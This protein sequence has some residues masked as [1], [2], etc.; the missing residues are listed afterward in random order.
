MN[1]GSKQ[2]LSD[3]PARK[4]IGTCLDDTLMVEAGAGTGKTWSLVERMVALISSGKCTAGSMAAVTFTRKA[5][6]ELENRFQIELEKA[7]PKAAEPEQ[8]E[9]IATALAE[10]DSAFIGTIHSFCSRILRERPVEAGISPEFSE[11]EGGEEKLL[12]RAAWHNYLLKVRLSEPWKLKRL[13]ELDLS[14][15]D[16][17]S[18]FELIVS[19]PDL[20]FPRRQ[21]PFPDLEGF[22]QQLKKFIQTATENLPAAP[23]ARWDDLQNLVLMAKRWERIHDLYSNT[24]AGNL[25]LLRLA[26]KLNRTGGRTLKCWD[27]KEQCLAVEEAFF[28]LR[29]NHLIPLLQN[30]WAYRYHDVIEFLLPAAEDYR[31]SRRFSGNLNFQD[32]LMLTA[33]LLRSNPEVRRYFQ[34]RFTHLLIDEFQDTDPIQA[35]IMLY[36]TGEDLYE[37]NWAALKPRPGSLFVVGDPKQSIYRFRRADIATYNQVKDIIKQSGGRILYL[38]TNFRS[39]PP[40]VKWSNRVFQNLFPGSGDLYQADF[41]AMDSPPAEAGA[42][43]QEDRIQKIA[44]PDVPYDRKGK[45]AELDA[46][47]IGS[48][49]AGALDAAGEPGCDPGDFLIITRYKKD[50]ACYARELENLGIPY[51]IT[52]QS[53]ISEAEEITELLLVLQAVADP[54]NPVYLAAVLRGLYYGLSDDQLYRFKRTG[55]SFNFLKALPEGA[56]PEIEAVFE[57]IWQQLARFNE[58][59]RKLPPSSALELIVSELGMIPL[60]LAGE[61]GRSKAGYYYQLLENLR[62]REQEGQTDFPGAVELLARLVEEG[63]EDELDIEGGATPA[64]RIMNLHK[65]K[66]LEAAVVFLANPGHDI[67]HEPGIHVKRDEGRSE[68]YLVIGRKIAFSYEVLAQPPDWL[69]GLQD[70][71]RSYAEAE[72]LRLLYVAATRA[73]DSMVVS[74]YPKKEEKS[75][76]K[77]LSG[78]LPEQPLE[79]EARSMTMPKTGSSGQTGPAELQEALE[80][81]DCGKKQLAVPTYEHLSVTAVKNQDVQLPERKIEGYGTRWGT[82]IHAA[83]DLLVAERG[84]TGSEALQLK[85][86]SVLEQEGLEESR[87]PDVLQLLEGFKAGK[88][89]PRIAASF[90]VYREMPFGIWEEECYT[91]GVIDL[92]FREA[93]G[94]V[95]VDY[96]TDRIEDQAHLEQL[97]S[98]YRPQ[99]EMYRRYFQAITGRD[100]AEA[101]LYFIDRQHLESL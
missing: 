29:D 87:L 34:E 6:G 13:S 5:A 91:T 88:L 17:W 43:D 42:P 35:E 50:M 9:R 62:A 57:P 100:I 16:L 65:A 51:R 78:Y 12:C 20:E 93:E 27:S 19:Y 92:A 86:I 25:A 56:D 8:A 22:R 28:N 84:N 21:M 38:T 26:T 74:T 3:A 39:R 15:E 53:N 40:L 47:R 73:M 85:L 54:D 77:M 94:W 10:L 18:A 58:F 96:K 14:P 30:W 59:T 32:L 55:G 90:E 101:A 45:I 33:Q 2:I 63:F 7:L 95:I 41:V 69:E 75:A 66:G 24:S 64:V 4:D 71:E 89:W 81:I 98:Y 36:L 76:W 72:E 49:I 23:P 79:I 83:L 48:W 97:V 67:S 68:G 11:I 82:V 52:G 61:L 80:A 1:N 60:I 46:A 44:V 70:E 37:S 31:E 99:V